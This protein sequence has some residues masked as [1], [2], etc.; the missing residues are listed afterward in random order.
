MQVGKTSQYSRKHHI[1]FSST[2]IPTFLALLHLAYALP[3]NIHSLKRQDPTAEQWR[4][5]RLNMHMMSVHTGLPGDTWFPGTQFNSTIDFDITLPSH[6]SSNASTITTNCF[7]SF[8]NGTLPLGRT[9]CTPASPSETVFFELYAYTDLGPRRPE[10]SFWLDV[11][12]A[13]N[14]NAENATADTFYWGRKAVTANDPSEPSSYLTC[15]AGKPFD[16]LRCSVGSYL[17]V[18]ED[19]VVQVEVTVGGEGEEE[20]RG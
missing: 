7:A 19:L 16:G 5:P 6:T 3:T 2:L 8:P 13:V 10:L 1:M 15:L 4:I 11:T 9:Y 12:S 18:R 14:W 17:S 20:G